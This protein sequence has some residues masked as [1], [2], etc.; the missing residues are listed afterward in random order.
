MPV[1]YLQSLFQP[2][3]FR[4]DKSNKKEKTN[5]RQ[6]LTYCMFSLNKFHALYFRGKQFVLTSSRKT[7]IVSASALALVL[8][9]FGAAA[10]APAP[11]DL[12]NVKVRPIEQS[13]A[14][15][16]LSDQIAALDDE[17]QDYVSEARARAGDTLGTLLDRLGI[18]DAAASAY[19]RADPSARVLLQLKPGRQ[20]QAKVSDTGELQRL[21]ST[22]ADR[23]RF[24]DLVVTR[25]GDGFKTIETPAVLERRVEM[26]S[27]E[28][29]SSLFA[30]TDAADIPDS[31]ATQMVDIFSTDIDFGADLR[32]GDRFT[33]VYETFWHDGEYVHAGRVLAAQF[34][35]GPAVYRAVWFQ[36]SADGPS[37]G[38]YYDLEGKSLKKAFLRSPLK[39]TR[40]SSGFSMRKDPIL[41]VWKQH[42]GVDFAAPM[43]TPIHAAGNGT[44]AFIGQQRGYGNVI[45]IKHWG[46]YSTVY[47]HMSRFAAHLHRGTKV[48]QG[49]LIGYVGMTGWA[50]GPHLHYEFRIDNVAHD[51]MKVNLPN[52]KPLTA[53]QMQEFHG[54]AS[55]MEHRL[56][57]LTPADASV[58]LA[59][60]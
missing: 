60:R 20:V 58:Q 49:Q 27:G 23:G 7:R 15:P 43:G 59:S 48:E 8:V 28:I 11:P 16:K 18:E 32:R 46:H 14:L 17:Q 41:G 6:I 38:G 39:Y 22:I 57:L 51:P 34:S 37:S 29:H 9:A 35:N 50:T 1:I 3:L 52:A 13:L 10:V 42:K 21:S 44:I 54:A 55:A 47:G 31:V 5:K 33:V 25:D 53:M 26:R 56:A 24:T 19:I 36:D 45:I 12:T 4:I 2:L 40:I 30:A